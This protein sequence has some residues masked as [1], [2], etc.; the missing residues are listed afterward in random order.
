MAE[1]KRR[2]KKP[3][4][5]KPTDEQKK[6][7]GFGKRKPTSG[8]KDTTQAASKEDTVAGNG[9]VLQ[10]KAALLGKVAAWAFVAFVGFGAV[11]AVVNLF[12]PSATAEQVVEAGESPESQ[13]AADYARGFVG[14]WL[15]ATS[16]DDQE[17]SQY[18]PVS[19][20]DITEEEP[21]EFRNVAVASVETDDNGVSTA[22]ISAELHTEVED[23]DSET[24][25]GTDDLSSQDAE[26]ATEDEDDDAAEED[27]SDEETE[28]AWVTTWYQVN[29]Y[30]DGETFAPMGWPAPIPAPE[31]G[32]EPAM[33]YRYDGSDEIEAA[34]E[35]F[36][37]A[38]VLDTSDVTRLTHPESD[39]QSLGPNPYTVVT[40]D[41]VTTDED[42]RDNMPNEGTTTRALV[43]LSLG[44][45][46]DAARHATYALTLETRGG[47]WEVRT[48]DP[49][50]ALDPEA[51]AEPT[52]TATDE[53]S[54]ADRTSE[55][56]DPGPTE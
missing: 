14:A 35:D 7:F 31:T 17:V 30:Y 5:K 44:T 55:D 3:A 9:Q 1:E 21:A 29:V 50:P 43:N 54:G 8:A 18:M 6:R 32:T 12:N 33:T 13:Q 52:D 15:R 16:E 56:V 22:I 20:G 2:K 42:H 41:D 4:K 23:D 34:I 45:T 28:T 19:R 25:T 49:A 36:V 47:R 38:Y 27:S 53:E 24:I 10:S 40:V 46:E 48:L 26:E 39:I 11:A 51:A 37:E